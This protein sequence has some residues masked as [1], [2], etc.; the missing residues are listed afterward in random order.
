MRI[1]VCCSLLF[2]ANQVFQSFG[3]GTDFTTSYL[4]DLLFFP[5]SYS[6][7]QLYQKK[8]IKGY[9]IPWRH[10][11]IGFVFISVLYEFI[12]PLIDKRF[13]SDLFDILFYLIGLLMFH[14]AD[15]IKVTKANRVDG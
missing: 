11:I 9:S 6:A 3:V 7:I 5:I 4:D 12:V 10:S 2:I 15:K 8:Q 13:T 14:L 1:L